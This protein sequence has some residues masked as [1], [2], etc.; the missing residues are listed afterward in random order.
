MTPM[1]PRD[2]YDVLVVEDDADTRANLRDVLELDDYR[3]ETAGTLAEA[4]DR[5]DWERYIAIILDRRLPDGLAEGAL[6]RLLNLAPR[7]TVL[8]VT[9]YRDLEGGLACLRAGASDYILKPINPDALRAS[10]G[11][12]A[13]RRRLERERERSEA[14]FRCLVEAAQCLIVI[15]RP[16]RTICYFGPYAESLTGYGAAEV[17]GK[18]YVEALAAS[19]DRAE[20]ANAIRGVFAGKTLQG[21]EFPMRTR[22]GSSRWMLWNA[23]RMEDYEGGVALLAVGHDIT[24]RRQAT[25][26]AL[27]SERL[28]AIG[29]M[30]TGLAHESRNALQRSKAALELLSQEVEDRPEALDLVARANKAQDHLHKLYEEVRG[31]AAPIVLR[32]EP[33]DLEELVRE[34][35]NALSLVRG[36][37]QV[38]FV[39]SFD[40]SNRR[41]DADAFALGQV[42]RNVLENSLAA[43]LDPAEIRFEASAVKLNGRP[44][45]RVSLRDNGPGLSPEQR[46]RIFEPFYTTKTRGT[47]LGMAISQRIV[48]AHGGRIEVGDGT[49]G[50]EIVMTLPCRATPA[51][52]GRRA[53]LD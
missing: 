43:C 6:P 3:V 42:L 19:D 15:L 53:A 37:R 33:C 24:D 51:T 32:L 38:T 30:V 12:I 31:Y 20:V 28:A 39:E 45:L 26:R 34:T 17:L 29:Q 2:S 8:I 5:H 27:Q 48:E 7:S 23:R 46:E 4:F 10:L 40:K 50:T 11:R 52:S 16:D 36:A 44:A 14:K 22:D 18:D 13:E 49:T 47:G 1:P 9:G 41:I 35:W 25:E 21:V